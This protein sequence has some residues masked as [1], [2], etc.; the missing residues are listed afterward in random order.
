MAEIRELLPPAKAG[1]RP[2]SVCLREVFNALLYVLVSACAWRLLP[3]DYPRWR[4]VYGYFGLWQSDGIWQRLQDVLRA[5]VRRKHGRHKH[6]SAGSI[7][8]QSVSMRG[9]QRTRG[10]G[11][12]KHKVGRKRH[13]CVTRLLMC[14]T[15]PERF[16]CLNICDVGTVSR[17]SC[18]A[19]GATAVTSTRLR[20]R[21]KSN[22]W[23]HAWWNEIK[24]TRASRL[25]PKVGCR[26]HFW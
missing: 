2:R 9:G 16:L 21:R 5:K 6:A 20:T 18:G 4:T 14:L 7:D 17:R 3:L 10:D 19:C 13:L 15:P 26:A 25:C 22:A 23:S 11:G 12:A 24:N 1:G 8:S